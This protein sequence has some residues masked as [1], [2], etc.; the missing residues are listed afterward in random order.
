V[1]KIQ[2][3]QFKM[4]DRCHIGKHLFWP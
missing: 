3:F 4:A 1:N 2:I